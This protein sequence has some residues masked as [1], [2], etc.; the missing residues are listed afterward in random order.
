MGVFD[1]VTCRTLHFAGLKF[2]SQ[3]FSHCSSLE[4]SS[5]RMFASDNE[6][7]ARYMVVSLAKSLTVDC[8]C[9][10]R[11]LMYARKRM[12]LRTEPCWTPEDTRMLSELIPLMTT[13][14]ILLSKK[15]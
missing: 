10:G 5:C 11:S 12:G 6:L 15:P 9:S 8:T 13:D 14:C 1:L 2:I 4:R 3:V 7:I